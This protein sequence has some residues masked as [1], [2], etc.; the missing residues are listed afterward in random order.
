[1]EWHPLEKQD[2]VLVYL[3]LVDEVS[4]EIS[5]EITLG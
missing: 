1:M 5:P 3:L 4:M 2:E